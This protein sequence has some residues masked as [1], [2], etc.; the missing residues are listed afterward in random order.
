MPQQVEFLLCCNS[1][2]HILEQAFNFLE[3]EEL[4][5]VLRGDLLHCRGLEGQEVVFSRPLA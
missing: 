5:Y 3:F 1:S 4:I 2:L